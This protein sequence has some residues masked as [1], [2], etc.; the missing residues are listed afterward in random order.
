MDKAGIMEGYGINGYVVGH[1][2]QRFVQRK[3]PGSRSWTSFLEC[4]SAA[5]AKTT[6]L[7][8]YKGKSV[9]QQWFPA[10]LSIFKSW[11]FTATE[12]GWTTD[13]TAVEWLEKVFI[14]QTAPRDSSARLLILDGHGSHET[15]DFIW[16]CL[17]HNIYLLFLPPHTSHV[18][19]PLDLSIFSPLKSAYR[20]E[21]HRL[22]SMTDSTPIS[23]RNFLLCY[24]KAREASIT[25]ENI[26]AGWKATGLWPLNIAK[27]LM[28]R[29][30]L[31]NSNQALPT[32][33]TE[34]LPTNWNADMLLFQ[35]S[36][37][38]AGKELRS[39]VNIIT[40]FGQ[41][42]LPTRRLLFRK[43]IKGFDKKDFALGQAEIRIQQLEAQL[44]QLKPR[45]RRKVQ[46]S[47]NSKFVNA[48][49]IREAQILA[50]DQEIGSISSKSSTDSDSTENC[51]E[52]DIL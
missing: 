39:Q 24:Q 38:K 1:A 25:A 28:S 7:V 31:E 3:Q 41:D 49:A 44:E 11:H 27:P 16:K 14:P 35:W 50:G 43:V 18:L 20:S 33:P 45:K 17:E 5:G 37:P 19:Q 42:D 15:T 36:T 32:T 30:L 51:I 10:D 26:K 47:P 34:A 21:L 6:S 12:N 40:Q 2:N 46:T 48:K 8:V 52:V 22:S 4:I 9:Q 23:K 13:K 29:L